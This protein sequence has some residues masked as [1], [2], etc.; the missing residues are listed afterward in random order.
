MFRKYA[1]IWFAAA[2]LTGV[3]VHG[4]AL[5]ASAPQ[6][7]TGGSTHKVFAFNDLGMHCFDSD[8]SVFSLLPPFNVIHAQV[9]QKGSKPQLL[10]D[11]TFKATYAATYDLNGSITTT[12][13]GKTNFWTY[14][15]KLFG[16]TQP[17]DT[18]ILGYKNAQ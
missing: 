14:L 9:V 4:G 17:P 1:G 6:T 7:E 15:A 2:F 18:G 12:S 5:A 11:S 13:I 3:A 10:T 16:V 8:F